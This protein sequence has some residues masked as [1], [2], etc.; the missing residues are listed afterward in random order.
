MPRTRPSASGMDSVANTLPPGSISDA[1]IDKA[2]SITWTGDHKFDNGVEIGDGS[3]V[4]LERNS[5]SEVAVDMEVNS[6]PSPGDPQSYDFAVDGVSVLTIYSEADGAG[7]VMNPRTELKQDL[8]DDSGNLIF[9]YGQSQI[10]QSILENDS[11]TVAGQSVALGA[12]TTL[13]LSNL[14]DYDLSGGSLT[15]TSQGFLDLTGDGNNIRVATGQAIEDGNGTNRLGLS[16]T[17]TILYNDGGEISV[18]ADDGNFL[19][20]RAYS[21]QPLTVRDSQGDFDAIKYKTSASSPG[22]L[23]LTN[24]HPGWTSSYSSTTSDSMTANPETDTEDGY[25]EVKIQGTVYQVPAYS[26]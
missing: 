26:Q 20:L 21:D 5:G 7:G 23:E 18:N 24:A 13:G 3:S 9:D 4:K 22:T 11:V 1:E 19:Q 25:I 2:I 12:S 14:D 8:Q 15:D 6:V 17:R 10:A 16:D